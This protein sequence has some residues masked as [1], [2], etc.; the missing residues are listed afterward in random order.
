MENLFAITTS[1]TYEC[2][3][4][5]YRAFKKVG[6]KWFIKYSVSTNTIN[7]EFHMSEN[8]DVMYINHQRTVYF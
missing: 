8:F 6:F 7:V 1:V 2:S 4:I 5:T 3:T